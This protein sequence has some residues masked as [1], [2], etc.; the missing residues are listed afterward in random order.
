LQSRDVAGVEGE[1]V[2]AFAAHHDIGAAVAGE[3]VVTVAG[4][5]GFC[6]GVTEVVDGG[7]ELLAAEDYVGFAGVDRRA[8]VSL[9]WLNATQLASAVAWRVC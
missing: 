2:V 3:G 6:G 7:G 4:D 5:E 8:Y 1:G 9:F